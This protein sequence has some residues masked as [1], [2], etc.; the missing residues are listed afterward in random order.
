[1]CGIAENNSRDKYNFNMM[2]KL[3]IS[4][5]PSHIKFG[6][7]QEHILKSVISQGQKKES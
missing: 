5:Y 3:Y 4:A 2:K 7:N 1:M 6:E